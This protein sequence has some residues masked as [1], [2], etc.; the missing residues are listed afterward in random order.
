MWETWVY[1]EN[2]LTNNLGNNQNVIMA[3][4]AGQMGPY[5][6]INLQDS[7]GDGNIGMSPSVY[8]TYEGL[9]DNPGDIN[10]YVGE[11]V[12]LIGYMYPETTTDY[13]R[14]V[15]VNGV[16]YPQLSTGDTSQ[17]GYP[18]FDSIE[19][20]FSLGAGL[21]ATGQSCVN[22]RFYSLRVWHRQLS[23]SEITTLYNAGPSAS[24]L[25]DI[26]DYT[27][28]FN[29]LNISL[30]ASSSSNQ[31]LPFSSFFNVYPKSSTE[32][33]ANLS[34]VNDLS[35]NFT[36][37]YMLLYNGIYEIK[38]IP[39]R[40]SLNI[41]EIDSSFVE[42]T[43]TDSSMTTYSF[44]NV[45]YDF[46]YGKMYM[47]LGNNTTDISLNFMVY[48]TT[49]DI[50][51]N[52]GTFITASKNVE[53]VSGVETII[54]RSKQITGLV[55]YILFDQTDKSPDVRRSA[56]DVKVDHTPQWCRINMYVDGNQVLSSSTAS[57]SYA[58][59]DDI[60]DQEVNPYSRTNSTAYSRG[61]FTAL[62]VLKSGY[63]TQ[64]GVN[65]AQHSFGGT[66][67]IDGNYIWDH[68]MN[69]IIILNNEVE[70]TNIERIVT[71]HAFKNFQRYEVLDKFK[72]LDSSYNTI[73]EYD[74]G[75]TTGDFVS[76]TSITGGDIKQ[77]H[78][79]GPADGGS[80]NF[81]F[82]NTVT[83]NDG[84]YLEY[85]LDTGSGI[86]KNKLCLTLD[87]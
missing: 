78:F 59:V 82:N 87:A 32:L 80:S 62:N 84:Q 86:E 17:S 21:E 14:G 60:T 35:G 76:A 22:L 11:M 9:N 52:L 71:H 12:H 20:N 39:Q 29:P 13:N 19:N 69:L 57:A 30:D 42:I 3:I 1:P 47:K 74:L 2:N 4:D 28:K 56:G 10:D 75:D 68:Y 50:S 43:G 15:Y 83:Y 31:I 45:S 38:N 70:Y 24:T 23:S 33:Y 58:S 36:D 64:V 46:Y 40:F 25:S 41:R 61:Y 79:I 65:Q 77:L 27:M 63:S 53:D 6:F 54:K 34:E 26:N 37:T 5:F 85:F 7:R 8:K 51:Y 18:T 48:D 66:H 55:K 81:S 67:A 73:V 49:E 16:H 72:L 44:G